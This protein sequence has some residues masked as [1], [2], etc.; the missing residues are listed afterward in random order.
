LK[1]LSDLLHPRRVVADDVDAL[2]DDGL[3]VST[4]LREEWPDRFTRA[5]CFDVFEDERLRHRRAGLGAFAG[6]RERWEVLRGNDLFPA[7]LLGID[8]HELLHAQRALKN[9]EER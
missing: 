6:F 1:V 3:D 2:A 7:G 9:S 8:E 5:D 4:G